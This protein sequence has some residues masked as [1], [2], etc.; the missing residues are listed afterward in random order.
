MKSQQTFVSLL[1]LSGVATLSNDFKGLII[2]PLNIQK[3]I[4]GLHVGFINVAE[5]I[6]GASIGLVS[7]YGNERK[8]LDIHYSDGGFSDMGFTTGI[9]RLYNQISVGWI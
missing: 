2:S 7:W 9:H 3:T 4:S 5:E 6:D 1:S 8:N